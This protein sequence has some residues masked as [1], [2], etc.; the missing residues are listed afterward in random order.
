MSA[1]PG[2]VHRA[3]P[4]A[5]SQGPPTFEQRNQG[6]QSVTG[7]M[8]PGEVPSARWRRK[9]VSQAFSQARLLKIYVLFFLKRRKERVGGVFFAFGGK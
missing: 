1:V 5:A 2:G 8:S 9:N 6:E 3:A 7:E 4:Q